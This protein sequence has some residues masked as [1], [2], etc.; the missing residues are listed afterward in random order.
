MLVKRKNIAGLF[1][2]YQ[3]T[4]FAKIQRIDSNQVVVNQLDIAN[5]PPEVFNDD[6]TL[7]VINISKLVR[8]I[9]SNSGIKTQEISLSIPTGQNVVIRNLTVPSMSKREMREA[10]KSEVENYAPLS[11]DEPVLDFITT[12]QTFEESKQKIEIL[13][14]AAPKSLIRSYL[15]G[16]ENANLKLS[17]IEPAPLSIFRNVDS[18]EPVNLENS[19]PSE[20]NSETIMHVSLEDENGI[21]AITRNHSIRFTHTLEFGKKSL[22]NL[23][24]IGELATK[25]NSSLTY[26]QSNFPEQVVKKV[27]FFA[28][29]TDCED[30]CVKLSEYLDMPICTPILPQTP[31][32]FT[33][34]IIKENQLSAFSAIGAAM[35]NKGEDCINLIPNKGIE[36]VN[37]KKRMTVGALVMAAAVFLSVGVTLSLKTI[38]KAVAKK[39]NSIVMQQEGISGNIVMLGAESEI[40]QLRKQLDLAKATL[41]TVST[42]QWVKLLPELRLIIPKLIWINNFSW[43]ENNNLVISGYALSYDSAF[44]FMDTLKASPYF[45][46]PQLTFIRKSAVND[47]DIIQFEIQCKVSTEK[48]GEKDRKEVKIG[49]S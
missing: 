4:V 32:E 45:A 11:S 27:I 40:V 19:D 42:V 16:I 31:D 14:S 34:T 6:G 24:D 9:L 15:V 36:T 23:N 10:L 39:T 41:N 46:Y 25:L 30:I 22:E 33:A 44:K 29:G 17:L 43:Q 35:Y 13:L 38:T 18:I 28:D 47:K 8:D 37:L 20:N 1:I 49:I 2:G 7:N 26:Y 3:K 21:I 5:T 12:G 48:L